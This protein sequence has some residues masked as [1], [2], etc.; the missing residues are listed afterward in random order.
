VIAMSLLE[1]T[2]HR[3][4]EPVVSEAD[5]DRADMPEPG[6]PGFDAWVKAEAARMRQGAL[7]AAALATATGP[8]ITHEEVMT[9][10]F[11]GEYAEALSALALTQD[12]TTAKVSGLVRTA[13]ISALYLADCKVADLRSAREPAEITALAAAV[14]DRLGYQHLINLHYREAGDARRGNASTVF[15]KQSRYGAA[16]DAAYRWDWRQMPE[17]WI[18]EQRRAAGGMVQG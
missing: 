5:R 12:M 2:T 15:P 17:E 16:V 1:A 4:T 18:A 9:G 11:S 13:M 7:D 8:A 6:C 14:V 10:R 3:T